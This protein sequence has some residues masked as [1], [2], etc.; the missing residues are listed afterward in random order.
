ML[1]EHR[2]QD[3]LCR[4]WSSAGPSLQRRDYGAWTVGTGAFVSPFLFPAVDTSIMSICC[5]YNYNTELKQREWTPSDIWWSVLH[6]GRLWHQLFTVLL[7]ILN[8]CQSWLAGSAISKLQIKWGFTRLLE[9]VHPFGGNI[10][11]TVQ[12]S[13]QIYY[14]KKEV[15]AYCRPSKSH[16]K[17]GWFWWDAHTGCIYWPGW[18]DLFKALHFIINSKYVNC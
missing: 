12:E 13:K 17:N 2:E 15:A 9:C 6:I 7:L 8:V 11:S 3:Y 18:F 5:L 14:L 16:R 1:T 4:R 10:Y